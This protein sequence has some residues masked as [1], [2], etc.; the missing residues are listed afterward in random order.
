MKLLRVI[1]FLFGAA[2]IIVVANN[3]FNPNFQASSNLMLWL[4]ILMFLI[5][6][7]QDHQEGR[8]MTGML[9]FAIVGLALILWISSPFITWP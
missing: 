2:A 8:K 6:G 3:I 9:T 4:F 7:I 5:L 1:G